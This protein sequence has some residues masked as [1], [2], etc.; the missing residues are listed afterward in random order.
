MKDK[1]FGVKVSEELLGQVQQMIE[2]SGITA[3]EWFEKAVALVEMQSIKEGAADYSQDLSEL[4]VHTTRIYELITNMVQRSI[5]LKDHAVKEVAD[6]LEQTEL[7]VGEFQQKAKNAGEE[8]K[9]ALELLKEVE[10]EKDE[11][12]KQLQQ[13]LSTHENNQLLIAEYKEK[14]DTLSGLVNT[15]KD[16]VVENEELREQFVMERNKL[17]AKMQ[18]IN[19][20]SEAK[21]NE[22]IE[23]QRQIE[24]LKSTHVNEVERLTEKL[25]YEKEKA[26]LSIEREYQ[27]KLLQANE[28]YTEKIQQLY[29]EM[30]QQR[31]DYEQKIE[32]LQQTKRE[33]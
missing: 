32:L 26:V 27:Q 7:T 8:L 11:L 4:E 15:Y 19:E 33:E 17:Q 28:S 10:E 24:T 29:N 16:F 5:Y 20:E 30:E 3:K 2:V 22:N 12:L 1:T 13:A 31:K 25:D 21:K 14:T 18:S 23:L 6:K 9:A